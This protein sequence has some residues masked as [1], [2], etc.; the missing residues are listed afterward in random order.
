MDTRF[1]DLDRELAPV[2]GKQAFGAWLL[3]G[4]I[5]FAGARIRTGTVGNAG[6]RHPTRY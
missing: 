5:I 3:I 2:S 4:A 1:T 6:P